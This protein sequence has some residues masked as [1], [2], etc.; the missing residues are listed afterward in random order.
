MTR[1]QLVLDIGG[2]LATNLSPRFWSL[3]A[4]NA[5]IS[6][7]VLYAEY[8]EQV[9]QSLWTGQTSEDGF[10][11][12]LEDRTPL[13]QTGQAQAF[14]KSSL[15]PLPGLKMIQQWQTIADL[16]ILSNHLSAWVE[17][18]IEPFKPL[19]KSITISS[20]VGKKKP[21]PVIFNLLVPHF[22]NASDVLF[23]DDQEKNV[24]QAASLGWR[25]L[26]AD[27]DGHWIPKVQ[28][29]LESCSK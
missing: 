12:W 20:E 24:K 9:S 21:D 4:E 29:L 1:P 23:I 27:E 13:L 15:E 28:P 10:W 7:S 8:K 17:P 16:H 5:S 19:F 3:L 18:I 26:L 25:T 22:A 14:L 6:E 2:V 11:K